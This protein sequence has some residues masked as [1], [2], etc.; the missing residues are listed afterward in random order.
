MILQNVVFLPFGHEYFHYCS[1]VL[2]DFSDPLPPP[3]PLMPPFFNLNTD[4]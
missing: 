2:P 1:T 3:P 4:N